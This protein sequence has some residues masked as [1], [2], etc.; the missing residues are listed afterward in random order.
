MLPYRITIQGGE[1]G[2][3]LSTCQDGNLTLPFVTLYGDASNGNFSLQIAKDKSAAFSDIASNVTSRVFSATIPANTASGLYQLRVVSSEGSVS[4][5]VDL[6]IGSPPTATL[7]TTVTGPITINPGQ[8]VSSS[9]SFTGSAPWTM[10]YEN[11]EK[12]TT[13]NNP[14]TR[15][16]T[17]DRGQ[18]FSLISVYNTCGYGTVSGKI[19]VKVNP[20][21]HTFSDQEEVCAGAT[22]PVRYVLQGD[23]PLDNDFIVF[24]LVNTENN[25]T[26]RVDSTK[27]REGT[28]AIKI[29]A[30]LPGNFYELRSILKSYDLTSVVK[31]TV[32]KKADVSIIGN[33]T[34]N[35][36]E[37]AQLQLK[38]NLPV[39]EA[40]QYKLSDGQTG[41]FYG[42]SGNSEFYTKVSPVKTTVYTIVS[43][44]NGCG[45]GKKS[46][47][48][49]SRS[50]SCE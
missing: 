11:S 27:N 40:I 29:P 37:N 24:Q 4:N 22:V 10:I 50:Q 16:L 2:K 18:E 46:G 19:T 7:G 41:T 3:N 28:I 23:A 6:F 49:D 8:D 36:G 26:I 30:N 47:S 33:T 5:V 39:N 12:Q 43:A 44:D 45:E 38:S 21:L 20:A 15:Y 25:Q 31:L 48:A 42:G 1:G 32:K 9:V 17:T 14:Y 13:D 35:Q 34:I